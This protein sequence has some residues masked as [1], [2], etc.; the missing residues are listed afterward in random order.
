M[1]EYDDLVPTP[2]GDGKLALTYRGWTLVDDVVWTMGRELLDLD[3]SFNA[4][5]EFP[6]ELGDLMLL[7]ELNCAANKLVTFPKQIGKLRALRVLKANGNRLTKLPDELG[8]CASLVLVNLGE[9][10]L[11]TVPP[12]LSNLA[13]LEELHLCNN[14]L[15]YFPPSAGLQ[16]KLAKLDLTNNP[17]LAHMVPS[18]LQGHHDFVRWMCAKWCVGRVLAS[19]GIRDVC[20]GG[21][22]LSTE[23][24][25]AALRFRSLALKGASVHAYPP[26]YPP[27]FP[28]VP[29]AQP[30][31]R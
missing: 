21:R 1:E 3:I 7:R 6:P 2:E 17:A 29:H 20:G 18:V 28:L 11:A 27:P 24:M 8:L 4:V 23:V 12:T 5:T 9:N 19:Q 31:P 15:N 30:R 25:F 22:G 26:N 10:Q 14:R 13:S 16:P